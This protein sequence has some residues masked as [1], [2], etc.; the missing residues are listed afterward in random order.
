MTGRLLP[1]RLVAMM[2][3]FCLFLVVVFG[4]MA[5]LEDGPVSPAAWGVALAVLLLWGAVVVATLVPRRRGPVPPRPDG[6]VL[7]ESPT[8]LVALLVGAWLVMLLAVAAWV[9]VAVTDFAAV[10]NPGFLLVMVLGGVG[11]LPDLARLLTGRLHRWR[12]IADDAGI[13]YRGYHTDRTL[14]WSEISGIRSQQKPP[15]VTVAQKGG[16]TGIVLP[17]IAFDLHPDAIA[18]ALQER[19]ARSARR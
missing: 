1:L 13:R 15:G 5:T 16:G 12:V 3:G 11:S 14:A 10:E 6:S 18:D 7:V 2:H 4:A 8:A 9:V 19:R 17:A